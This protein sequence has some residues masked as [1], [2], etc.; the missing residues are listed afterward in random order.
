MDIAASEAIRCIT[1][2]IERDALSDQEILS[3][4]F[5]WLI[6][7]G[8]VSSKAA[9]AAVERAKVR[10]FAAEETLFAAGDCPEQLY[11]IHSG[12]VRFYYLTS[13]GKEFNKNFVEDGS[14]VTSLSS[15][16]S[17]APSPFHT[18]AL[19]ETIVVALPLDYVRAQT[20]SDLT[21]ERL[22]NRFVASLAL[23]KEQREASFLLLDASERYDVFLRDFEKIV[24]RLPQ[25]H[26]AAYLGITPVALSRIRARR[27]SKHAS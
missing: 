7:A 15:F 26:I 5:D 9:T 13:D 25:Y 23:K 10:R 16:L 17:A 18:Q 22:L 6:G 14:V 12:L 11:F 21:W 8:G 24:P 3:A 1:R 4:F 20:I 19:E 27:V 2:H